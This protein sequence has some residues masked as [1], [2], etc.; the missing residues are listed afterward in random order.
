[1]TSDEQRQLARAILHLAGVGV[2][3]LLQAFLVAI[4]TMGIETRTG[5]ERRVAGRPLRRAAA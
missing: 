2:I 3:Q 1:V 5:A 4:N